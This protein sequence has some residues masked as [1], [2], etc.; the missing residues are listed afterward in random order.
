MDTI[1]D[2]ETLQF[3]DG[4]IATSEF[5]DRK[6]L[7]IAGTTADDIQLGTAGNDVFLSSGGNDRIW[8]GTGGDDLMKLSGNFADYVLRNN[9]DGSFTITNTR[10]GLSDGTDVV[11]GIG[12]FQFADR[13]ATLAEFEAAQ[14]FNIVRDGQGTARSDILL[15]S[16]GDDILYGNAG[17]DVLNGGQ[18]IDTLDGGAG[19]DTYYIDSASDKVIESSSGGG[20]D[21]VV[22]SVSAT[23]GNNLEFLSLSGTA[24]INATGNSLGNILSGNSGNNVLNGMA[25]TDIM[26]GGLGNDTYHVDNVGDV[27]SE[28]ANGGTD[29]VLSSVTYTLGT[30]LEN[31]SL[32]GSAAI[33]G[34]GNELVN[35]LVGNTANNTLNGM[36]GN[37]I[38]SGGAGDDILIGGAG[39]DGLTGGAGSDVFDFNALSEMGLTSTRWD[40][41]ND[42]IGGTDR[43]D[44]ST[45]DAN[46][47]TAE[48]DAF[49]EVIDGTS[50]FSAAGQLKLVDG[51][52]Y[53]NIDGDADAEFAIQLVGVS[54]VTL[55]DFIA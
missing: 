51:V 11:R 32:T 23:L 33:N 52:L 35:R 46:S 38:L 6:P 22:S 31:L 8:G 27:L 16:Y 43:I 25:G 47:A 39:R 36:A 21:S 34:T 14:S 41:I 40:V 13:S 2:I 55:A 10:S 20:T 1:R 53:G 29:S 37:D 7:E 45:L 4:A 12:S 9:G 48:N 44:L 5:I 30:A 42:F 18:G 50:A 19:N 49:S 17:N 54:S 28:K 24:S 26:V 15:G 3:S